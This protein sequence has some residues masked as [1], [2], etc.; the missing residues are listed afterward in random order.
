MD[1]VYSEILAN[2]HD[3]HYNV[4]MKIKNTL[5]VSEARKNIFKIVDEAQKYGNYY[6]LTEKGK[7]KIV[8]MSAEEFESWRETLEVMEYPEILKSVKETE[9]DM[10]SG[11]YK[12]YVT[13]DEILAE[14]G[15]VFIDKKKNNAIPRNFKTGGGKRVKKTR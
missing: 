7:P 13:L 14:E 4:H 12:N 1:S 6:T 15:F 10:K 2:P 5:P 3:V 11:A 8:L 9:A